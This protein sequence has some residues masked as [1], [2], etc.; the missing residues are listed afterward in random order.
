MTLG[1]LAGFGH[2]G[3]LALAGGLLR[4]PQTWD[5]GDVACP[6]Y[7]RRKGEGFIGNTRVYGF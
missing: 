3:R 2:F 4:V 7:M 5:T 1:Y 6:Q